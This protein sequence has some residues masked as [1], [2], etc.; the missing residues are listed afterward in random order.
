MNNG[1]QKI[2]RNSDIGFNGGGFGESKGF[3]KRK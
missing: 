3:S 2:E 1:D